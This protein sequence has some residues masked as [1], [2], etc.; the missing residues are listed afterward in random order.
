[1]VNMGNVW[2]RTTEF[3]SDNLA[4]ILPIAVLAILVPQAM[5]S[6]MGPARDTIGAG[7]SQGIILVLLLPI[8]WGQ[9]VI[10]ALA[11][12]ANAGRAAAQSI[13]TRRFGHMLLAMLLAFG[14]LALLSVP[15]FVALAVGGADFAAMATGAAVM[16]TLSR[17]LAGFVIVYAVALLVVA[18]AV[19]VRL[20]TLLPAVV[21]AEGG[22]VGA[23]RRSFALTRGIFWKTFGVLLLF[24]LVLWV[25]CMAATFV[26]GAV[27]RMLAPDAGP[28][29]VGAIVVAILI[30][31]LT[32]AYSVLVAAFS[33]KLYLAAVAAREG[34]A[35]P[36]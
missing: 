22:V 32:T 35:K 33:A 10:T 23:L 1:M 9:L 11:V 25:A 13:A 31:L 30:G 15:I 20:S 14:G 24:G 26:F 19:S 34:S 5:S 4:A 3:L 21:A 18:V 16:P 12:N 7:L 6:A 2:D 8:L 36:T 29:G 28:F 27:F 17:G